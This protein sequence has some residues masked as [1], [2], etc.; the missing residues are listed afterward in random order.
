[1]ADEVTEEVSPVLLQVP[2]GVVSSAVGLAAVA[3]LVR[4]TQTAD[5]VISTKM[6]CEKMSSRHDKEEAGDIKKQD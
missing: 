2:E 4:R 5:D 6:E 1:M 3:A